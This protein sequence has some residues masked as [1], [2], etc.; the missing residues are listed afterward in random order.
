M[1]PYDPSYAVIAERL[2]RTF[3][4]TDEQLAAML[5]VSRPTINSWKLEHPAFR[6]ALEA[7]KEHADQ[8]VEQAIFKRAVGCTVQETKWFMHDGV[9][10]AETYE[11]HLPSETLAGIYWLN[12]RK[13][14]KWKQ[15]QTTELEVSKPIPLAYALPDQA[16]SHPHL[17][18]VGR[19]EIIDVTTSPLKAVDE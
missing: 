7:G 6:L 8:Q 17:T 3:G 10:W 5:D 18:I 4:A 12:N 15:R 2:C 13:P 19:S 9:A 1:K 11:K 16:P 14:D